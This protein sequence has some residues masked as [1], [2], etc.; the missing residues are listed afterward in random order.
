MYWALR[1]L[2]HAVGFGGS[3]KVKSKEHPT[4]EVWMAPWYL[5]QD[6]AD[7]CLRSASAIAGSDQER[8]RWLLKVDAATRGHMCML[9]CQGEPPPI[10]HQTMGFDGAPHN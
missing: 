10:P 6:Y 4:Q 8:R 2:A 9:T 7:L 3:Y 1:V 5:Q